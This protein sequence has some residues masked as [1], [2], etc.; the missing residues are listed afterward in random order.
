MILLAHSFKK[1]L[2]LIIFF[3][4]SSF[5][6]FLLIPYGFNPTD[7]GLF[8]SAGKR[9]LIGQ[10]PHIDFISVRPPGS[11]ILY[12][13]FIKYFPNYLF[14]STRIFTGIQLAVICIVWLKITFK[15]LVIEISKINKILILSISFL[16]TLHSFPLMAHA[17]I[18]GIFFSTIGLYFIFSENYKKKYFGYFLFGCS[19][20][21]KQSF[22]F[23]PFLI[24][25]CL[26]DWKDIKNIISLLIPGS[27]YVLFML[28]IGGI[29]N[30]I[31]QMKSPHNILMIFNRTYDYFI[32]KNV[33]FGFFLMLFLKIF[34]VIN[35]IFKSNN[36]TER[37]ELFLF[38][39]GILIFYLIYIS[40]FHQLASFLFG[41]N[42]SLLIYNIYHK[43]YERS[44]HSI[45]FVLFFAW[46]VSLSRGYAYPTLVCGPL[47][48][49]VFVYNYKLA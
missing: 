22:L 8:L 29:D 20:L 18:D 28:I 31:I 2:D 4:T 17:T 44:S 47:F 34:N 12:S 33:L 43:G 13:V 26:K 45:L 1:H 30:V 6:I 16:L 7:D 48:L 23:Q 40:N 10:I 15:T 37:K 42:V 21:F 5:F 19:Y 24:L 32:D 41:C 9:I 38:N 46:S 14:L 35:T 11:A 49:T 3:I 27:L 36:V 25:L 39:F